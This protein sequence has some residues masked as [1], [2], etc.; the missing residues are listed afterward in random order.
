MGALR[1]FKDSVT[2]RFEENPIISFNKNGKDKQELLKEMISFL[3][4]AI[5]FK[6]S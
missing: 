5:N 4:F 3:N 1:Q 6:K 2:L